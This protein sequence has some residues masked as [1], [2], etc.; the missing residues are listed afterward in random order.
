[1]N[2]LVAAAG[3]AELE[4]LADEGGPRLANPSG[5][6][7]SLFCASWASFCH[8]A[9]RGLGE[10]LIEQFRSLQQ[11]ICSSC[12]LPTGHQS[13][14]H[15]LINALGPD[16]MPNQGSDQ[17][18]LCH[19]P[20]AFIGNLQI[21]SQSL[22]KCTVKLRKP[23]AAADRSKAVPELPAFRAMGPLHWSLS[24]AKA[25]VSWVSSTLQSAGSST[26]TI[27]TD[28]EKSRAQRTKRS[29]PSGAHA[30]MAP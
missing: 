8:L 5:V 20:L 1:M 30:K 11:G 6:S 19:G 22:Q 17:G 24:T 12:A 3:G 10:T 9:L 27:S 2:L 23:L 26:V 21:N 16:G 18:H 28:A 15:H 13:A 29:W 14:L 25:G 7:F 4:A